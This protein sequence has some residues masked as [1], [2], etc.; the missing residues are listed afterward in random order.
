M[1]YRKETIEKR[2]KKR[3]WFALGTTIGIL[4]GLLL[5]EVIL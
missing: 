3:N 1:N 5:S 2:S 4:I